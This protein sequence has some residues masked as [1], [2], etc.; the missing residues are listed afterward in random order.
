MYGRGAYFAED[1][2]KSHDYTG[3]PNRKMFIVNVALG[4]QENLTAPNNAKTGPGVG[5]HS[6]YGTGGSAKEYIIDRLG[7]AKLLYL[8]TY[9]G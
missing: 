9:Q 1:P 4:K 2:A 5:Y 7:Q 8:I 6:I 3:A